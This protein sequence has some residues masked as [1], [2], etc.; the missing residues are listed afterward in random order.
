MNG[1]DSEGKALLNVRRDT[2]P[3]VHSLGYSR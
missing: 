1:C 2:L 3:E